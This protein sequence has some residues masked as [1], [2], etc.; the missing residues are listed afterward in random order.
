MIHGLHTPE[1]LDRSGPCWLLKLRWKGAHR[2]QMRGVLPSL[3]GSLSLSCWYKRF[4]FCLGCPNRPNTKYFFQFNYSQKWKHSNR[5]K[6][7][8][9]ES[10]TKCRYLTNL[11]VQGL[12]GR[13]FYLSEAPSPPDHITPDLPPY[14]LYSCIQYTYSHRE[15]G[16]GRAN[17]KEGYRGTKPVEN[18]NMTDCISSL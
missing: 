9:I 5:R 2:V 4:L 10:N 11:P 3:V 6:T 7:R 1:R 14:T 17:Q 8:L 15:G 13:L 16:R 12:C 18:T